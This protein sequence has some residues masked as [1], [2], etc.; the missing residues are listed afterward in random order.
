MPHLLP[1]ILAELL[2]HA[3]SPSCLLS[4]VTDAIV[5]IAGRHKGHRSYAGYA[6]VE[7]WD[8]DDT[9]SIATGFDDEIDVSLEQPCASV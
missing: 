2:F 3:S 4:P 6:D 8:D 9:A 1:C 7:L 5:S